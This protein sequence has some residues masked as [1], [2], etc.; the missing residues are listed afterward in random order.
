MKAFIYI[1]TLA[2][3]LSAQEVILKSMDGT[4]VSYTQQSDTN[5][6]LNNGVTYTPTGKINIIF[7]TKPDYEAFAQ[8]YGLT[9]VRSFGLSTYKAIYSINDDASVIDKVNTIVDSHPENIISVTPDWKQNL[10]LR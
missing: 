2:L 3:S 8:T 10:T 6:F 4:S 5:I 9:L 7:K 1:L